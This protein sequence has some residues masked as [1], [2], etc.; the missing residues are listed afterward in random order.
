M[1]R[2]TKKWGKAKIKL[3]RR[4]RNAEKKLRGHRT[5]QEMRAMY[6]SG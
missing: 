5:K 6:G 3:R 4:L 2:N 1:G